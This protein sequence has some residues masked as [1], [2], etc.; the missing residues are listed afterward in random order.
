MITK[1]F[2]LWI[3]V[4][5]PDREYTGLFCECTIFYCIFW[6]HAISQYFTPNMRDAITNG[7]KSFRRNSHRWQGNSNDL[8]AFPPEGTSLLGE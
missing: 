2:I 7:I 5:D 3:E 1:H 6:I 8:S 4:D